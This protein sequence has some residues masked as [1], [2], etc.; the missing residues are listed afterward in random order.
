MFLMDI[1]YIFINMFIFIKTDN[2]FTAKKE[3]IA[4]P[5][6]HTLINVS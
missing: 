1:K 5:H 4:P 6:S 2:T 3:L